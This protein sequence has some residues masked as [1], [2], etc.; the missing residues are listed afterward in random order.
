MRE[1]RNWAHVI[2]VRSVRQRCERH[3]RR[4]V[5]KTYRP[6][7][8]ET[9]DNPTSPRSRY[10]VPH[11]MCDLSRRK[12]LLGTAAITA[13]ARAGSPE[14]IEQPKSGN[15]VNTAVPVAADVFFHQGDIEHQGHCNNGWIIF[16]DYVLVIDANFPSGAQ[17][18]LPK[19]RAV[20]P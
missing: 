17:N 10:D 2:R 18:I 8:S 5:P 16:K 4:K 6:K 14:Q 13:V 15:E 11:Y 3:F 12:I 7:P 9:P 20:T 1:Y 19:I